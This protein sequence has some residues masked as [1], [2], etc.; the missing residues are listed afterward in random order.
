VALLGF[1]PLYGARR[2][3]D[4]SRKINAGGWEAGSDCAPAYLDMGELPV[5]VTK[6]NLLSHV[7][8]CQLVVA[9]R[10]VS[11]ERLI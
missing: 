11:S 3:V 4:L 7:S 1:S 6:S 5:A 2:P 8:S 9:A 10:Y